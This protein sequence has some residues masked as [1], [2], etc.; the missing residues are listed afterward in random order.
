MSTQRVS[1]PRSFVAAM[2]A[3]SSLGL[4]AVLFEKAAATL[5]SS[6]LPR[7]V[8]ILVVIELLN[9]QEDDDIDLHT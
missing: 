3:L 5:G 4:R 1:F 7:L 2:G 9:R 8:D 6:F